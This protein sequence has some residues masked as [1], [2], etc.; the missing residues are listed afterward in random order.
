M[1]REQEEDP[2][3]G[4]TPNQ[5]IRNPFNYN[6]PTDNNAGEGLSGHR[7]LTNQEIYELGDT[8]DRFAEEPY[9]E[10]LKDHLFYQ[11]L[12]LGVL[13]DV[14]INISEQKEFRL[15]RFILS[16]ASV[17][18][19]H[20]EGLDYN[21]EEIVSIDII[22]DFATLEAVEHIFNR[23]YGNFGDYY[24]ECKNLIPLMAVCTQLGLMDWLYGYLDR[25]LARLSS[26][27]IIDLINF[28]QDPI[29]EPAIE[30]QVRDVVKNWML[31]CGT[32]LHMAFWRRMPPAWIAEI[33]ADDGFIYAGPHFR[34]KRKDIGYAHVA[35]GEEFDRWLF[36]RDLYYSLL[37]P[38]NDQPVRLEQ[39]GSLPSHLDQE[40]IE[41][42]RP[43]FDLLNSYG[44]RY[45]NMTPTQWRAVRKERF[46]DISHLVRPDL[47]ADCIFEGVFLRKKVDESDP[48]RCDLGICYSS[49]TN[50]PDDIPLFTVPKENRFIY[51]PQRPELSFEGLYDGSDDGSVNTAIPDPD[52]DE[53][54]T[55]PSFRFSVEFKF[56]SGIGAV[57]YQTPVSADPVFYAGNWWQFWIQRMRDPEDSADRIWMYLK[58]VGGPSPTSDV[59]SQN[60][61]A[62]FSEINYDEFAR[63]A[64]KE[65]YDQ[66][67]V[68]QFLENESPSEF[69]LDNR[70]KVKAY[71][72]IHAPSAI[73]GYDPEK[74]IMINGKKLPKIRCP[75]LARSTIYE[76]GPVEFQL[77]DAHGLPGRRLLHVVEEAQEL[78]EF[79]NDSTYFQH[80]I[81]KILLGD[82]ISLPKKKESDMITAYERVGEVRNEWHLEPGRP[83]P[84]VVWSLKEREL[85][86]SSMKF[87]IVIGVI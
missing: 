48:G 5:F 50:I 68:E 19:D 62:T 72:R 30:P 27:T 49:E 25:A 10:D 77:D 16:Q 13:S 75:A 44:L 35:I 39:D 69:Y 21:P 24:Y 65:R 66:N 6:K 17:L 58:R 81:D 56:A 41:K 71:F 67:F 20:F 32:E 36:T 34:D 31:R 46:L 8:V 57:P 29:Y 70:E 60:S 3:G 73:A 85:V 74:V 22:D 33:L 37:N 79:V 40:F 15:H 38:R 51:Q 55:I 76:S 59:G 83:D 14:T 26:E 28:C 42:H 86:W 54:T 9:G 64:L 7:P 61:W 80:E 45:S 23:M 78:K 63:E 47:I 2:A 11:G 87:A 18:R 1:T 4:F 12:F 52:R 53:F 43:L 84:K 82:P